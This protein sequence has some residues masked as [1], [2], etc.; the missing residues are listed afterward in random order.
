M[1]YNFSANN[2]GAGYGLFQ[3]YGASVWKNNIIR[4]N[5][6]YNDGRK[7]GQA[8]FLMWISEGSPEPISNCRIENNVVVNKY[9]HAVGFEPG[10]YP[11][12]NFRNNI[13][14]L[15]GHSVSFV[16]GSYSGVT[17]ERNQAWSTDRKIPLAFPEDKQAVL[18]DPK[19]K[20]PVDDIEL[21]KSIADL[22]KMKLFKTD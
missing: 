7:N 16:S 11:G 9:G 19:I 6:S 3:Y 2:E 18:I 14:V 5:I 4:N 22:K 12:F 17:F 13:F 10:N 8:G 20:L 1:Q 15:T 21:P